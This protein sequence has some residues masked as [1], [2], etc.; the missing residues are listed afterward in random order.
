M[1][2]IL[3]QDKFQPCSLEK[4]VMI[5]YAGVNG[6][7]DDLP[8][9]DI[10]TFENELYPFMEK[11]YKQ[12]PEEIAQKKELSQATLDLLKEALD[13]FKEKFKHEHPSRDT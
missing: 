5:I 10:K 13:K 6:Y 8:I 12:I 9:K 11:E 7:L 2:E 3:K 4:E 1:V